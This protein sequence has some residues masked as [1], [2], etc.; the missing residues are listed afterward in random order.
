MN[1]ILSLFRSAPVYVGDFIFA[2]LAF[3]AS[4]FALTLV[5]LFVMQAIN[6]IT[7]G[8]T[9]DIPIII[10][11]LIEGISVVVCVGTALYWHEGEHGWSNQKITKIDSEPTVVVDEPSR[12]AS[13]LPHLKSTPLNSSSDS[14]QVEPLQ[15]KKTAAP[16]IAKPIGNSK[17]IENDCTQAPNSSFVLLTDF[18]MNALMRHYR[19]VEEI[20]TKVKGVTFRNDD[21]TDRQNILTRCHAGDQLRFEF[22]WYQ[23]TPAYAVVS[24]HGQLGNVSADLAEEIHFVT[25]QLK[26]KY[27]IL[28]EILEISGGC[29]GQSFGCNMVIAI[30]EKNY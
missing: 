12:L 18:E 24:E 13:E 26:N 19:I 22:Y 1:K 2:A 9:R 27:L 7:N 15:E 6:P 3:Y 25:A 28:G 4:R 14:H 23:G 16:A 20:R 11:E 10:D 30:Y 17:H 8:H 5:V 29:Q 21:G